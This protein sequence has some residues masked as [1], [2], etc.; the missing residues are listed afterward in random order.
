MPATLTYKVSKDYLDMR[1]SATG[2]PGVEIAES[3]KIWHTMAESCK[4]EKR[5]RILAVIDMNRRM[6][7]G[8]S[9]DIARQADACGWSREYKLALVVKEDHRSVFNLIQSFLLHLGYEVALFER[10]RP[11]RKW[12]LEDT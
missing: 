5:S 3:Q 6:P 10:S 8:L 11:A 12:L 9:Y 7:I 1:I 2:E 4:K